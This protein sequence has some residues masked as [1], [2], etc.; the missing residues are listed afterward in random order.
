MP[1]PWRVDEAGKRVRVVD[2]AVLLAWWRDRMQASPAH[3][4]RMRKRMVESGNPAPPVPAQFTRRKAQ[5]PSE[6]E[7]ASHTPQ[8]TEARSGPS[9][10][11]VIADLP[12]FVGQAEHAALIR[13]MEDTPPPATASRCSRPTSSWTPSTRR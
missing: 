5:V 1:M 8:Q 3:F 12:E 13:A 11:D 6:I 2:E 7:S 4:Y 9:I 10:A